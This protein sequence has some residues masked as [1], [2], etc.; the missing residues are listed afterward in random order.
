MKKTLDVVG[1]RTPSELN[2]T[3]SISIDELP[4]KQQNYLQPQLW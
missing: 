4:A 3:P 1:E 2:G